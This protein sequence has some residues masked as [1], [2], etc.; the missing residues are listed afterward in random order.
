MSTARRLLAVL[1]TA[2]AGALVL[3]ALAAALVLVPQPGAWAAS[4]KAISPEFDVAVVEHIK[5]KVPEEARQAWLEAERQSWE[6]WLLQQDGFLGRELLWDS[7]SEEGTLLIRWASREQWKA[8]P[9][10]EIEA[11]QER[12]EQL[13]K[14]ATGSADNPFPVVFEGE[15]L[16]P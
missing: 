8:I 15:L 2:L 9:E 13:A 4:P 3:I 10:A 12:F 5:L 1:R 14:V 7:S 11:V 6:P 16:P